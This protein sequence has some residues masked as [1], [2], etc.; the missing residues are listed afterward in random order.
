MMPVAAVANIRAG[1]QKKGA[2]SVSHVHFVLDS[3]IV[4][5]K[6][7]SER[8][9][10]LVAAAIAPRWSPN[11]TVAVSLAQSG[12]K[13]NQTPAVGEGHCRMWGD[14]RGGQITFAT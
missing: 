7:S 13:N 10:W 6:I 14:W 11:Y 1:E 4:V 8:F 3:F 12:G 9:W 2:I 5:F